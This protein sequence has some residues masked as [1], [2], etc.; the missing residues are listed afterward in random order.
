MWCAT[1]ATV[2][3]VALV[4]GAYH[5]FLVGVIA[6]VVAVAA[7]IATTRALRPRADADQRGALVAVGL[8]LVF[9]A[10]A[11]GFHSEHL[12][13]DRDPAVYI[14]TGRS[15]ARTHDL[16]PKTQVG[17]FAT[18][19]YGNPAAR[20]EPGFFPMLPVLLALG[21]S[22]GGDLGLLL[23]GPLLGALGLLALYAL[24]SRVLDTRLALPVLA[25][26]IIGPFQLWFARD[27]YS[28]LVVQFVVLG[29]LW[30]YLEARAYGRA[31]IAAMAG[32]V[33]ASSTYAR[34]DALAIA[35]GAL[36]FVAVEWVR[37][38]SD[39]SPRRA[40]RVV[41]AFAGALVAKT[42]VAL[43]ITHH[44]A[45]RYIASLGTEYR[46]LV[47]AFAAAIA[48]VIVVAVL[49]RVRPGLARWFTA[50]KVA[51]A[52]AVTVASAVFVWA[53]VARPDPV[54]DLP[55]VEAGRPITMAL[56]IAIN[57]W[58]YSR[59]LHW[60][61][62]YIGVVGLVVAFA[63][64]VILAA[65]ARR[66]NGAA[67]AVFLVV[68]PVAVLY[69][70]RPKIQAGQPWAMRRFLPVVLPGISI[71]IVVALVAGW[72]AAQRFRVRGVV[73]QRV[74]G[75]AVAVV[76][77]LIVVPTTGAALPFVHAR[78][79]HGAQAAIHGICHVAGHDG[80]VLV[81]G[82]HYLDAELP[83]VLR[84]FCGVPTAHSN[85]VDLPQ[86]A[87]QWRAA[88]RRLLVATAVP[89]T[90]LDRAPGST[91]VGNFVI[92]DDDEPERVFDRAP[93]RFAPNPTE[94]WLVQVPA[95]AA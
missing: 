76:A 59:S 80:A 31:G 56:R 14:T 29:G 1:A 58:H 30:L 13:I 81:Y 12:L 90:V 40:R 68:I 95:T 48:G 43:V 74:A 23:V 22:I 7:S 18:P 21:W 63:G 69:I 51:F 24:A 32:A 53:Y 61:S 92:S 85:S 44:V 88:G 72:H 17:P 50:T 71:A 91:I 3:I 49:H 2:G 83:Q 73:A 84:A 20:A 42:L 9:F 86:L 38:E 36:A 79:Q 57:T 25:F 8:V 62:A 15:I 65:R 46:L 19:A 82:G 94:I 35:A 28:E 55:V 77:L 66:G 60:F 34:I 5:A 75:A 11:G 70:A 67:A 6:T 45:R 4:A 16:R 10:L 78:M 54:R 52:A 64:F 87:R 27:A 41:A 93:G 89:R 33:V 37:C 39:P 26:S 47:G